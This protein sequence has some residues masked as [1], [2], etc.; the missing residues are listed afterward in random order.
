MST[1]TDEPPA[2]NLASDKKQDYILT[3]KQQM[4]RSQP[5]RKSTN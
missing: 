1:K 2:V 3:P 4:E 5:L